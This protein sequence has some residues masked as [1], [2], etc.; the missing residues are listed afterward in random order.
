MSINIAP[1]K[2]F[3][4]NYIWAISSTNNNLVLVDPG[5]AAPCIDYINTH[6][7]NLVAI[8]ITHHHRDHVGGIAELL[9]A[10]GEDI[11]VYGPKNEDI[12]HCDI[13]LVEGD[14]VDLPDLGIELNVLDVPGHTAGHIVYFDDQHLFCGDT[15][16]SGGCGR[17][18]EGTPS[19]MHHSVSKLA[20]LPASTK[21]YC[22]HEYTL[23]NLHFALTVEPNNIELLTYFNQVQHKRDND[24]S[25]I[26][27]TIGQEA[28]INPFMRSNVADIKESAELYMDTKLASDVD[29]FAAIRQWKDNF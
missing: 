19:Q 9:G 18:F 22:A 3:N 27:T 24:I 12:P 28:A 25:T 5:Q 2:A 17:L 23:A 4:D 14:K 21:V 10:F 13:K 29:V 15:L 16:F 20:K 8:L 1:I 7:L 6:K 11:T 26:P